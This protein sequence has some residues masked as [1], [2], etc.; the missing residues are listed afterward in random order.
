[1]RDIFQAIKAVVARTHR[2]H[3]VLTSYSTTRKNYCHSKNRSGSYSPFGHFRK[4]GI[5]Q[6]YSTYA[7]YHTLNAK[8]AGDN[9]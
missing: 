1:M 3:G 2:R 7:N 6:T 4:A 8:P 9:K 5:I